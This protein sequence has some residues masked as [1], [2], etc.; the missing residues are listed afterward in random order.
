MARWRSTH[1]IPFPFLDSKESRTRS[2]TTIDQVQ[3]KIALASRLR[4]VNPQEALDV[5][6]AVRALLQ[7][8]QAP[9]GAESVVLKQAECALNAAWANVRLGRFV[10]AC[11]EAEEGLRLF[12]KLGKLQGA[13][14][15]LLVLGIAKGENGENDRALKLCLEAEALFLK[16]GDQTGRARAINATGTSYRRLGDPGRAIEAYGTSMAVSRDNGDSQG[17]A[18]ALC[19]IGYVYLYEKKY[20]QAMEYAKRALA[21]ERSLGNLAGEL[22]NCCN[23]IQALVGIE[24]DQR[25][26]GEQQ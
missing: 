10:A 12:Q 3:E 14:G 5:V 26:G 1:S 7:A 25:A 9:G 2:L 16:I 17:E 23:L 19:N 18:R 8:P 20:E 22:S 4:D 24:E 13:A 6:G 11:P 15:C 21:M